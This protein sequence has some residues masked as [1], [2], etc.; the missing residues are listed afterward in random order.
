MT[1]VKIQRL[2]LAELS[3]TW[4]DGHAGRYTLL[5]LRKYCP[6]AGC[7]TEIEASENEV[8]FPIIKAGQYELGA[9][10][11]VGSYALQLTWGDGHRTG[12]YTFEY[13]RELC[14]CSACIRTNSE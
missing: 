11:P 7:K 12:I 1:P 10:E 13:L 8:M 2:G 6:C 4:D 9:I 5:N 14:E 3:I